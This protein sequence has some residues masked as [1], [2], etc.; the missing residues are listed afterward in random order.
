MEILKNKS[1]DEEYSFKVKF[2]GENVFVKAYEKGNKKV[3]VSVG[4]TS[5]RQLSESEARSILEFCITE[6]YRFV[7]E[8]K[9][10]NYCPTEF[11]FTR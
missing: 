3:V 2:E 10:N 6:E 7:N 5:K 4:G 8:K 9:I 1:T 11:V